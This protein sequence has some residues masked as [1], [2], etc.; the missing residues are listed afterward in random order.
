MNKSKDI[1]ELLLEVEKILEDSYEVANNS[2]EK[3]L[4][5]ER[6]EFRIC[7]PNSNNTI[8]FYATET[9]TD[10]YIGDEIQDEASEIQDKYKALLKETFD[11]ANQM[12]R[13]FVFNLVDCVS[14]F[15]KKSWHGCDQI[16]LDIYLYTFKVDCNFTFEDVS[17]YQVGCSGY[18]SAQK[19]FL[20]KM[21]S[22]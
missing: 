2:F 1:R 5:S 7:G 19:S 9:T 10:Y 14:S 21:N 20:S 6:A 3:I 18:E 17:I 16:D 12:Q 4:E 8:C 15:S 22:I 13:K 11:K